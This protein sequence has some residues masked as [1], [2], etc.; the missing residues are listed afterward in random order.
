MRLTRPLK[1]AICIFL[2]VATF[3]IYSQIQDHEFINFD[4]DKY[5][6]NNL[7]VQAGLTIESIKWAFTPSHTSYWHPMTWLSHML[8]YQLYGLHPKGH[9]LTNLFLHISSVLILFIV[10]LR[11]TGALW[12]SGFVAAMFALHPLNVESVA[13]I[14][15]RKNVLSTLF[16]L[17]TM[18]A[19]I[20]YAAKPT[21]KRYGLVFLFFTLGLM[22][23]AMLVTLPFVLLLLDYWPLRR[24]KFEQERGGNETSEKNTARRSEVFRLVLEK[25]PLFLLTT[26]LSIVTFIATKSLGAIAENVTFSTRLTNATVSNLEYLEKMIWP[27][28]LAIFYAHPGN[29]LAVWKGI[30]CGMA[31]VGIT[32]ISIRLIKKAPYFS[33]GWFWYLGTLVPVIGMVQVG[34]QAM[35]DRYAYVAL[36]GIFIIVA[37]GVPELI[38][39]WRYKEKVL[40]AVAGIIIFTL[41]ITTW[42]QVS[43]WKNSI[44][45]FKHA[46]RVTD[47]KYPNTARIHNNLGIA[48]FAEQKNEEA[49][50]HLKMA[51]KLNPDFAEAYNN[52]GTVL[53]NAKM[54]EEA[55]NSFKEAIRIRPGFTAAQK[56]LET[57]LLRSKE[58]E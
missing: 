27:E 52:L 25:I 47:K 31:L 28:K 45:I 37:W 35:A 34:V 26:G 56:N 6:T 50:S 29:T 43:H 11:M 22:S 39:K 54:T 49:I 30:L 20:H 33:V 53:F 57:A 13:W 24:L 44:T 32:I 10:L 1:V 48:L 14:A 15:E 18:W 36:I 17:L 42:R 46:I 38:S 58:L 7:N 16:W 2:M 8:D 12:K 4:D 41:L 19:Y 3:C 40:S 21:I 9:Y 5:I 23:K 51:I 55:I